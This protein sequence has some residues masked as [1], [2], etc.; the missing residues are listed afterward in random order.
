[1]ELDTAEL[2][3]LRADLAHA[4][5]IVAMAVPAVLGMAQLRAHWPAWTE[6]RIKRELA[7]RVGLRFKRGQ[8]A[9]VP[10]SDVAAI[11][12]QVEQEARR[13]RQT[14][15]ALIHPAA[16]SEADRRRLSIEAEVAAG[17]QGGVRR[18]VRR[19]A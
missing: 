11:D 9:E 12:E 1:M 14:T 7:Q 5:D 16:L 19:H 10:R 3:A 2:R 18:A 17:H 15:A 8:S 13:R 4:R 6:D